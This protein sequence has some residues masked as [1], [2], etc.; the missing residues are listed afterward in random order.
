MFDKDFQLSRQYFTILHLIRTYRNWVQDTVWQFRSLL[1]D[2]RKHLQQTQQHLRT[3]EERFD[4]TIFEGNCEVIAN[5]VDAAVE[6]LERK[7]TRQAEEV[8]SLRDRLFNASSLRE[9]VKAKTLNTSISILTVVTV[10]FTPLGFMAAFCAIPYE[11]DDGNTPRPKSYLISWLAVPLGTYFLAGLL[12][13]VVWA[14]PLSKAKK[15]LHPPSEHSD[16]RLIL[17]DSL[18]FEDL[19]D[20]Q[21]LEVLLQ[22][23]E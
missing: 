3:D 9:A 19:K 7:F 5:Y 17:N 8:E 12:V 1:D 20:Q 15:W 21:I 2:I 23:E 4:M 18:P 6:R 10:I 11:I 22:E 13:P 16:D 14:Q